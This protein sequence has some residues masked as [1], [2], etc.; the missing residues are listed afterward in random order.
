MAHR[1]ASLN[2]VFEVLAQKSP[3]GIF[4]LTVRQELFPVV[5]EGLVN[6]VPAQLFGLVQQW[7]S[8]EPGGEDVESFVEL[9]PVRIIRSRVREVHRKNVLLW[10][11]REQSADLC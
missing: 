10:G 2:K 11:E 8:S 1:V 6:N 4:L 5:A 3:A 7:P 9:D